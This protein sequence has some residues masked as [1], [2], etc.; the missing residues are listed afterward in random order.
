MTPDDLAELSDIRRD[1]FYIQVELHRLKRKLAW[2]DVMAKA[3]HV[4]DLIR[5][6]GFNPAQLRVPAGNS[7][8]GQWARDGGGSG[9][10]VHLTG[11]G[12][13]NGPNWQIGG[14]WRHFLRN[15]PQVSGSPAGIRPFRI[16]PEGAL[17]RDADLVPLA[18]ATMSAEAAVA[19]AQAGNSTWRPQPELRAP[20]SNARDVMEYAQRVEAQAN[21]EISRQIGHNRGPALDELR[22][23]SQPAPEFR[24]EPFPSSYYRRFSGMPELDGPVATS[25][26]QGTVAYSEIDG[27]PIFGVNSSAPGYSE[28]DRADATRMRDLLVEKYPELM[29]VDNL[30]RSKCN[31]E[32]TLLL[33]AARLLGG[34][35]DG[36]EI[37]FEVDRQMCRHCFKILPKVGLELGN[38]TVRIRDGLGTYRTM[39]NGEWK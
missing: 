10:L 20:F 35:L 3:R 31:A 11:G 30:G 18:T 19:R 14:R 7:D 39:R 13:Q 23:P 25:A 1:L 5:K 8:G 26:A 22:P 36:Q 2:D 21:A 17:V 29:S 37:E 38:P 9:G 6:A 12:N 15:I 34:N 32:T 28:Q 27:E 16:S 33:R 4:A 24:S